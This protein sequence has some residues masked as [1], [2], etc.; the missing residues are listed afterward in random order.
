MTYN[1]VSGAAIQYSNDKGKNASDYWLKFYIA[2]T[3]TPLSMATDSTGA[4]LLAKCKLNDEGYPI[5]N[6]NDND[7]IF[8]PHVDQAYRWVTYRTEAEADANDTAS[9]QVNIPD[10][11][12]LVGAGTPIVEYIDSVEDLSGLVGTVDDQQISLKGWHPD[13]DMGGGTLYWDAAAL[14]STH[15]GGTIFSPTVPWTTTTAD[16]LNAVGETDG[17]GTGVW[18]RLDSGFVT[19]EQFG[20]AADGAT[21]DTAAAQAAYNAIADGTV[22]YSSDKTYIFTDQLNPSNGCETYAVGAVLKWTAFGSTLAAT[23]DEAAATGNGIRLGSNCSIVGG[24][25]Q[26]AAVASPS[27]VSI[28]ALWMSGAFWNMIVIGHFNSITTIDPEVAI[29]NVALIGVKTEILSGDRSS[30]VFG[31]GLIHQIKIEDFQDDAG[32]STGGAAGFSGME[33]TW[34]SGVIADSTYHPY[35]LQ[36][37]AIK[38]KG[39][40]LSSYEGIR[41]S[42]CYDVSLSGY[43]SQE[44]QEALTFYIG[45]PGTNPI[46]GNA[47]QDS[48]RIGTGLYAYDLIC[49]SFNIG[50]QILGDGNGS[51]HTDRKTNLL[52]LNISDYTLIGNGK[53]TNTGPWSSNI[54]ISANS[55][56]GYT[57][58]IGT[59][60]EC[61]EAGIANNS[62]TGGAFTTP[63]EIRVEC[64]HIY[65]IGKDGID[66]KKIEDSKFSD[67]KIH[68]TNESGATPNASIN[69][70][71][72]VDN[73]IIDCNLGKAGDATRVSINSAGTSSGNHVI[74]TNTFEESAGVYV[75]STANQ[76]VIHGDCID[77][78]TTTT[79]AD[80]FTR[81]DST[82]NYG[83]VRPSSSI[84]VG[85]LTITGTN[86]LADT[87]SAAAS[88]DLDD[89]IFSIAKIGDVI[90]LTQSSSSRVINVRHAAGSAGTQ[91]RT[92]SGAAELMG[93]GPTYFQY[94]GNA[95]W[96]TN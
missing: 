95:W 58:G 36:L 18:A 23:V 54:G 46:N 2:N 8:I 27:D 38:V 22:K 89:I 96:K 61:Y 34:G 17:A 83:L 37:Q 42:G 93:Q 32:L 28:P 70:E 82:L 72:A 53:T 78:G 77:T 87:E 44:T 80:R 35:N 11:E 55:A 52:D 92:K 47:A 74:R 88:D 20:A 73:T 94:D 60:R 65:N 59:I 49:E 68:N 24:T 12:S 91:T 41:F 45:D 48:S 64:A 67:L 4:T 9:A 14:K 75:E 39:F 19:P 90:T 31:S 13:S 25:L 3:T 29:S 69:I 40:N 79:S 10:V 15:N 43:R 66:F 85:V 76:L 63:N 50:I 26:M 7:T 16:Y 5:S 81:Q 57:I 6:E 84:A 86:N 71:D 51:T 21:D 56:R 33:F 30:S 62:S 1:P